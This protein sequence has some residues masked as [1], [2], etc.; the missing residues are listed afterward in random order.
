MCTLFSFFFFFSFV[1]LTFLPGTEFFQIWFT[2][3]IVNATFLLLVLCPHRNC[4]DLVVH[5]PG[6]LFADGSLSADKWGWACENLSGACA[7]AA[8]MSAHP[9]GCTEKAG[10]A[11]VGGGTPCWH[12]LQSGRRQVWVC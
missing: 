9:T 11:T 4:S 3:K 8:E 1:F 12:G 6:G 2:L 10:L 5:L 7:E